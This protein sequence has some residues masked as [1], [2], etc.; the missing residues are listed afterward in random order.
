MRISNQSGSR[1]MLVIDLAS[2]VD[3][4]TALKL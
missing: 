2:A 3:G 4:A 1:E